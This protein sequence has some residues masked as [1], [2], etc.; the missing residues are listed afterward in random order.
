M[1]LVVSAAGFA[2]FISQVNPSAGTVEQIISPSNLFGAVVA[3]VAAF[4]VVLSDNQAK[5]S[6][7]LAER[8]LYLENVLKKVK[9]DSLTMV[10]QIQV[11]DAEVKKMQAAALQLVNIYEAELKR[12]KADYLQVVST[13]NEAVKKMQSDQ[14]ALLKAWR[15]E[16]DRNDQKANNAGV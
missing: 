7:I 3:A 2:H 8:I 10:G 13:H 15:E 1:S 9:K 16:I 12:M 5:K 14:L 4:F 11:A 6:I